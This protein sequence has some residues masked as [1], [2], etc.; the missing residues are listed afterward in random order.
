MDWIK[1]NIVLVASLV[2]SLV[3]IGGAG[4]YF[5]SK[6][7]E[8]GALK[9]ELA[10]AQATYDDYLGKSPFPSLENFELLKQQQTNLLALRARTEK[11]FPVLML[12]S[13]IRSADFTAMLA[14]AVDELK[15]AAQ[16]A[17]VNLPTNNTLFAFTAQRGML[18]FDTNSLPLLALQLGDVKTLCN[19]LFDSKV[20]ELFAVKR[21]SL[22]GDS[23]AKM[24]Y[25]QDYL[26]AART[27]ATNALTKAVS[28]PYEVAFKGVSAELAA[29]LEKMAKSPAGILVKAVTVVPIEEGEGGGDTSSGSQGGMVAIAGKGRMSAQMA[30]R[31]GFMRGRRPVAAAAPTV[32]AAP[33][34]IDA[35]ELAKKASQLKEKPFK[36]TIYL[37]MVK[38]EPLREEKAATPPKRIPAAEGATTGASTN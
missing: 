18:Q 27:L 37:E 23:G 5:Y 38:L 9:A 17:N 33:T 10:T 31:Y 24:S 21:A 15:A 8:E 30:Q 35:A 16:A 1:Q 20:Y 3:L 25:P 28:F 19:I 22:P 2:V 36:A 13:K 14:G 11:Q 29:V 4:Y 12:D 26:P 34:V 6:I 32:Q 7:G